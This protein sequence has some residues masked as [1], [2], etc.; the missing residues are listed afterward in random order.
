MA[1]ISWVRGV[2]MAPVAEEQKATPFLTSRKARTLGLKAA[3]E[4]SPESI[5]SQGWSTSGCRPLMVCRRS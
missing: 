1:G 4:V 5:F 3:W 2:S